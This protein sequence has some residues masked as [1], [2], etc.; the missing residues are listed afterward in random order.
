MSGIQFLTDERGQRTAA[1]IDLKTHRALWEDI[2]DVLVSRARS[3]EKGI[4]LAK[5]KA[6]LIARG[7][8]RG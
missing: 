4:P 5:V 7:K 3:R 2:Q 1:V 6:S 8:L